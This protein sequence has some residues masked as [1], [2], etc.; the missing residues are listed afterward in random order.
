[1]RHALIGVDD[2]YCRIRALQAPQEREE[3]VP[4]EVVVLVLPGHPRAQLFDELRER[5]FDVRLVGDA[6]SP[7]DMQAAIAEGYS[8]A[9]SIS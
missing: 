7:R 4:A 3:R 9:R 2:G 6:H 5:G 8:T 1:V